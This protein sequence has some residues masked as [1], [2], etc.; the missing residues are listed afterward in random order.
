M[1]KCII[2]ETRLFVSLI[3]R[4][5][6]GN[7]FLAGFN[8]TDRKLA[9]MVG[10]TPVAFSRLSNCTTTA[11]LPVFRSIEVAIVN[12]LG[13]DTFN[14]ILLASRRQAYADK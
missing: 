11:S 10:I 4:S 5:W 3:L 14:D 7:L 12:T 8:Y 2:K 1:D 13:Y 9:E 6:R